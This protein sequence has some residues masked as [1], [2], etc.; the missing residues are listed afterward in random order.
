MLR[1]KHFLPSIFVFF[2]AWYATIAQAENGA[3]A[4]L[5]NAPSISPPTFSRCCRRTATRATGPDIKRRI[6]TRREAAAAR[7][8]RQRRR[9]R[10][11]QEAESRLVRMIAGTDEEFGR[12][13]PM[14]RGSH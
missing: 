7:R 6:A 1:F 3:L 13:P 5:L 12:M 2:T 4:R 14:I 8:R 9:D 10:A 11:W